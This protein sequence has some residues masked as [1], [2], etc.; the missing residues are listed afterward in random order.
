MSLVEVNPAYSV[1]GPKYVIKKGKTPILTAKQTRK[2]LD[3]IDASTIMGLRDRAIIATMV[4]S[5]GRIS[6][7]LG[8]NV[9]DY[10]MN[11]KRG[12]IRLHEKGGKFHEVV[13]HH[14]LIDYLDEYIQGAGIGDGK[15][16]PLFRSCTP[17]GE[18]ITSNRFTRNNALAMIK[19]RCKAIKLPESICCHS[20]R[21]TGITT[22]LLNGG[23][24]EKAQQIAA[25]ESP[26]TTKLY[27]RTND[28]VSLD[29]IEKIMI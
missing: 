27:D 15:K 2:L 26:R 22:Y 28:E 6:A 12:F 17:N 16:S 18:K 3:S 21:A 8:M 7:V 19:R 29:E 25:H 9:A 13:A 11:G 5:F 14:K 10:Y 24:V 1:R 23:T 20:F 4:Y